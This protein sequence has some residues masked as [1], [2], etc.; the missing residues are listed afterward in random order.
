MGFVEGAIEEQSGDVKSPLQKQEPAVRQKA[1]VDNTKASA[2]WKPA[3]R[4]KQRAG[5]KPGRNNGGETARAGSRFAARVGEEIAGEGAKAGETER[6]I[7]VAFEDVES[8]VVEAGEGPYSEDEQSGNA[9]RGAL[10]KKKS[11]GEQAQE[12]KEE[13]F[14]FDPE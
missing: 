2:G 6:G 7:D 8:E 5:L 4:H 14:E 12:E 9:K 13:T 1:S 11:G 10:E 3:L